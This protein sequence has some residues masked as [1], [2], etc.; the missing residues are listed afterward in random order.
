MQL[1]TLIKTIYSWLSKQEWLPMLIIRVLIGTFF[2]TSG[3]EKLFTA[4]G[5][6]NILGT[7]ESVGIPYPELN[8]WVASAAEFFGG[9]FFAIGFMTRPAAAVLAFVMIV[10]LVTVF[11]G[12]ITTSS[13]LAAQNELVYTTEFIYILMFG[14]F[15]F[16]GAGKASVDNWIANH[17]PI[18]SK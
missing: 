5:N 9:L 7:I 17:C 14:R 6:A 18:C 3:Y 16:S 2:M 8:A 12:D 4:E 15:V 11:L 1:K 13:W 10:A